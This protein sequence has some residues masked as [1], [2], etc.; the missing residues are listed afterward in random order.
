MLLEEGILVKYPVMDYLHIPSDLGTDL[1]LSLD[2]EELIY[3]IRK[4]FDNL[5]EQN[6][7]EY[8]MK[9]R[10]DMLW[11]PKSAAKFMLISNTAP[12]DF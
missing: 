8:T 7:G 11:V 12:T 3:H 1:T 5:L 6:E 2:Q 10:Y 4:D 9:Y